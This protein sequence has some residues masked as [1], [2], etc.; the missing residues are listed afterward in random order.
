[1]FKIDTI[2]KQINKEREKNERRK[3]ILFRISNSR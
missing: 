2:T 1:M 3:P